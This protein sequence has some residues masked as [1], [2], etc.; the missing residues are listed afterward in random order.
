M[1]MPHVQHLRLGNTY[2][3]ITS[4]SFGDSAMI[5]HAVQGFHV[6]VVPCCAVTLPHTT[7]VSIDMQV[8]KV[9]PRF[10]PTV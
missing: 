2:L 6:S 1:K 3:I 10:K 9:L 8:P 4:E 7:I 5:V